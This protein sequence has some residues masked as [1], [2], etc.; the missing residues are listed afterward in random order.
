MLHLLKGDQDI[1]WWT[2][3]VRLATAAYSQNALVFVRENFDKAGEGFSPIVENP[4]G[5]RASGEL[6]MT[7]Y[8]IF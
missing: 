8:Q 2:W 6:V 7:R 5:A 3:N 1:R 4:S